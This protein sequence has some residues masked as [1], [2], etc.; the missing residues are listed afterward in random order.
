ME[1]D[2]NNQTITVICHRC[3]TPTKLEGFSAW[4]FTVKKTFYCPKCKENVRGI[5]FVPK[6]GGNR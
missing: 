4:S 6:K 2:N 3:D 5:S 1:K